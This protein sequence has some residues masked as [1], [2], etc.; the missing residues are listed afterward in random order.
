MKLELGSF[1]VKEVRFASETRL[2]KGTLAINQA[3]LEAL[4]LENESIGSAEVCLARPGES[5]RILHVLD[6][7]EPRVKVAG[8]ESPFPG[9]LGSAQMCGRGRTHRLTGV[10]VMVSTRF[11]RPT[12]GLLQAREAIVDMSGPGASYGLFSG[13]WNVVLVVEAAPGV[14]NVEYE[15]ALRQVGLQAARYLGETVRDLVPPRIETFELDGADPALPKVIYINQVQSQ[16]L[17]AQT[18]IYGRDANELLPTF[19]HPNETMDGALV[20]GNY[21]YGCVKNPTY[22]HC[23]NPVVLECY[24]RHGREF[25]FLG[26]VLAKGHNYTLMLKERSANYAAKLAHLLGADGVI[27]SQEGGGNAAID[28]MLTVKYCEEFGVATTFLTFEYGGEQGL[29]QPLVYP[30]PVADA[31]VSTGAQDW[32]IELPAVDRAI[33]GDIVVGYDVPATDAF[34][35]TLE[36]VYCATNQLGAGTMGALDF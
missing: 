27:I 1:P 10:S 17:H 9:F 32:Q 36:Q 34:S 14:S 22:L 2:E 24:K 18:F 35:I 16:G 23:N 26:V 11:P 28:A 8:G 21:V 4:L 7:L 13:M 3:E 25:D 12:E 19:I 6:T 20:S 15:A 30:L 33:G 31:I 5:V 29:D